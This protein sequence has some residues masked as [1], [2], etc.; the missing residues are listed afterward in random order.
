MAQRP[1]KPGFQI[2][3]DRLR[4]ACANAWFAFVLTGAGAIVFNS[5]EPTQE[6]IIVGAGSVVIGLVLLGIAIT[7]R[8]GK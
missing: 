2:N 1:R 8:F 3:W 7:D 5:K 6:A 4:T